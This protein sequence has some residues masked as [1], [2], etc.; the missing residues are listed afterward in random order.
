MNQPNLSQ[1]PT[2]N[3]DSDALKLFLEEHGLIDEEKR[4]IR[5]NRIIQAITFEMN[6]CTAMQ[7]KMQTDYPTD[8]NPEP[9]DEEFENECF[10]ETCLEEALDAIEQNLV[11]SS[12]ALLTHLQLRDKNFPNATP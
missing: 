12:T 11:L 5:L 10:V 6:L 1:P 2:S 8:G 9:I 3:L 4:Q 7:E